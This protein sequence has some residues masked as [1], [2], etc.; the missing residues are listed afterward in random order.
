MIQEA[1]LSLAGLHVPARCP[2]AVQALCH[3]CPQPLPTTV[4]AEVSEGRRVKSAPPQTELPSERLACKPT[5]RGKQEEAK[6]CSFFSCLSPGVSPASIIFRSSGDI[7]AILT[8]PAKRGRRGEIC[9]SVL[10][11]CSGGAA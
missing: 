7:C 4:P 11:L 2:G 9:S 8:A 6:W 10:P 3:L 1:W 5:A